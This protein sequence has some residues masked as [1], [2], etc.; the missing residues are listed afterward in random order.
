MRHRFW[1]LTVFLWLAFSVVSAAQS[2]HVRF[3]DENG[4]TVTEVDAKTVAGQLYFGIEALK[5][6]FDPALKQQYSALTKQLTLALRGKQLRINVDSAIVTVEPDG[7]KLTLSPG[8]LMTPQGAMLPLPFFTE[9]LPKV[10]DYDVH[11]NAILGTL[12]LSERT[13]PRLDLLNPPSAAESQQITVILD[14]GHGGSDAG[15]RGKTNV[16]EK[17]LVLNLARQVEAQLLQRGV[18]VILTRD[19]DVERKHKDRAEVAQQNRAQLFLTLHCNASISPETEG[20]RLYVNS[21]SGQLQTAKQTSN[22]LQLEV[23]TQEDFLGQSRQLATDLQ[24]ELTPF[25]RSPISI[26]EIPLT[27]LSRIYMPGVLVEAGFL[28]NEADEARLTNAES[29]ALIG[30]AIA[31]AIIAYTDALP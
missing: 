11:F 12:Q 27:M 30:A 4:S 29:L 7:Q 13:G 9:L 5:E 15:C 22:A 21:A 2:T 1:L 10:F 23:L 28:S 18:R 25:S 19:A 14:P 20:I 3:I 24:R 6:A 16:P 31:E 26:A 8:L 17:E